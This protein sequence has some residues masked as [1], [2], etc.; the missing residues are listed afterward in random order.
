MPDRKFEMVNG[1]LQFVRAGFLLFLIAL[2]T[3]GVMAQAPAARPGPGAGQRA[4]F[5]APPVQ[6]PEVGADKSVTLRLRAPN[7]MAITVR[8]ITPRPLEMQKDSMG[9]W[10]ATTPPLKPDLYAYSFDVDGLSILDPSNI[11]FG[12]SYRRIGQN[13]V[14]VPGDMPWTPLPNVPRGAVSRH[15]FQSKIADDE[16]DYFVYS[17]PNYDSKRKEPYPVLYLHHGWLQD[18]NAWLEDGAANVTLDTLINQGKAVPMV[19]VMPHAYGTSAGPADIDLEEMLPN[20]TRILLEELLPQVEKQYNVSTDPNGRAIAGLSMGGAESMHTGLNH[21]ETFAWL[22][23]FSGAYNTWPL[24]RP[25]RNAAAGAGPPR[26][27]LEES[28]LP[29]QFPKLDAKS[30]EQIKLLW[31][32]CGTSDFGALPTNRQFK[33]YLDSKGVKVTYTETPDIGHVWPFWRQNLADFAQL[34][35]K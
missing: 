25:A 3:T 21:L 8:G 19:V 22:G 24:T 34:L 31:I 2:L 14:L 15:V 6:S 32:A 5:G 11:R 35:F 13:L 18:T 7:A 17:P 12:S 4:Q 28:K 29:E 30:N 26:F 16:R 20:Y 9:V 10:S 1:K 27:S 33:S 23:S